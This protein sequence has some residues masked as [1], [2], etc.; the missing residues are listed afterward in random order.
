MVTTTKK[1]ATVSKAL[2]IF[3]SVASSFDGLT[4]TEIAKTIDLPKS[5]AVRYLATLE[6]HRYLE[7]DVATG[8]Y[9]IG[10]QL[11]KIATLN[12]ERWELHRVAFPYMMKLRE[13]IG[14]TVNL[15]ILRGGSIIY[16]EVLEG[17]HP[18]KASEAI[19][20]EGP[21]HATALGKAI[22]AFLQPLKLEQALAQ[23]LEP[24]TE[25]TITSL[26]A[27]SAHLE[28]IRKQ[29]F[30][31]DDCESNRDIRCVGAALLNGQS[32]V[33]GGISVSGP[34]SRFDLERA[35]KIGPDVYSAAIRIS[36][37]FGFI[38]S[39]DDS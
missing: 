11:L 27:L 15:G 5:S 19:G 14:E 31:I 39:N 24:Y 36:E 23:P 9:R 33:V 30:A 3:D 1:L 21:L 29:G 32:N 8:K 13:S 6:E 17:F 38:K 22:L 7:R 34:S 35:E 26:F 20:G 28:D 37:H 10:A 25:K 4:L 2:R 16:L 12:S 18:L